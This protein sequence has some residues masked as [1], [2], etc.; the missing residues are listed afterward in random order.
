MSKK[1]GSELCTKL[2]TIVKKR[3][4]QQLDVL[5]PTVRKSESQASMDTARTDWIASR[6]EEMANMIEEVAFTVMISLRSDSRVSTKKS[7]F[8]RV[9]S[10][11]DTTLRCMNVLFSTA[12]T[13][14]KQVLPLHLELSPYRAQPSSSLENTSKKLR[15]DS[16]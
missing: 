12:R 7:M 11:V 16:V 8:D 5:L 10:L 3:V 9:R 14:V 1:P 4:R 2:D 6:E 15:Q 13:Q